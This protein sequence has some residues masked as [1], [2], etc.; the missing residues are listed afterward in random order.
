MK[1]ID[2]KNTF[3]YKLIY[4]FT[5]YDRLH[6]GILKIGETTLNTDKE[7]NEL[8]DNCEELNN[9]AKKRIRN[10][11][12]TI[13]VM[14]DLLYTTLAITDKKGTFKDKDVH[15]VLV[16][17]GIKKHDFKNEKDPE[18]WFETDLT[19]VKNA[20]QAVK[21][22]INALTPNDISYSHRLIQFRP[23]QSEAIRKTV[24]HFKTENRML[25]NAKMRFGKTLSTLEV[26]KQSGFSK[27]IIL[28]HRPVVNEGWFEDFKKI[29]YD[30][31]QYLYGSKKGTSI[32]IL[33]KSGKKI[34]YFASLQDLRE[35]ASVGGK[36]DK[37]NIVFKTNWDFVV[38]DEAH[39]G[40]QT[41]LGTKVLNEIIKDDDTYMTKVLFL[42]GTPF[43]LLNNFE[44]EE[45]YTWDYIMEQQ[46]KIDWEKYHPLEN[47]PYLDLPRLN[48]FTYNLDKMFP[49]YIDIADT[50]FNFREFFRVW[51]GDIS[52]DGKDIPSDCDIG[53]FMHKEDVKKFL[54]LMC[55]ESETSNYP[56]SKE[57]YIDN[58][59]HSFWI[60]PGIKDVKESPQLFNVQY[61]KC[62]RHR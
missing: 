56:F 1:I 36:F 40:T 6:Q 39:E 29:F 48:I 43:N 22:G 23:E 62:C 2:F 13:G 8:Q 60:V 54:D 27:T 49:G 9:A 59:R 16:N 45:V 52:K 38:I 33:L 61:C 15:N 53:D 20:I 35:S 5:I 31:D 47:N 17:S 11:T 42:S 30:S 18:E 10:Y 4:V 57:E 12:N 44:E 19:T 51:T 58:F 26:I 25:W 41:T 24:K 50:A 34:I 3:S 7:I 55:R 14:E 28:T 32:E 46:A 37:N 21:K